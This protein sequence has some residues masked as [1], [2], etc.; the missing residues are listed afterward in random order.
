[1][2]RAGSPPRPGV[3]ERF[4]MRI[5]LVGHGRMGRLVGELAP[6]YGCEVAGVIDPNSPLHAGGPG[7]DRWRG[8]DVAIDFS[9][10]DAVKTN[11]PALARLGVN[12]VIGTTG[13]EADESAVRRAAADA[14]IGVVAAPNFAVG[15]VLF[16]AM[17]ARAASLLDPQAEFGA[18]LHEAHHATKKDAPSGTALRL[19]RAMLEAGYRRPIDV[20]STRAGVIPGTHTVGF[21]GPSETIQLSHVARDRAGFARGALAAAKWVKGQQGWFTMRDVLGI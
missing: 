21:D 9:F 5:L 11:A 14:G 16:E 12:M 17:V 19:K 20:S 10:P 8:V 3:T 18:F 2:Q 7:Q 1:M 4:E 13:W 6:E 15:V